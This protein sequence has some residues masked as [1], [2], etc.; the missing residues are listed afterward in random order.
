MACAA[1]RALAQR[2]RVLHPACSASWMW[3]CYSPETEWGTGH[4]HM[5]QRGYAAERAN[6]SQFPHS[7]IDELLYQ[8][9]REWLTDRKV[10]RAFGALVAGEVLA[11]LLEHG[12]A[13]RQVAQMVLER[14]EASD[15]F[16]PTLN[17][18]IPYE[19]HCSASG[20]TASMERRSSSKVVRSGSPRAA[21]YAS[22]S[23]GA[24]AEV[25]H[26]PSATH[27]ANQAGPSSR[28]PMQPPPSDLEAH[29]LLPQ[30]D[31]SRVAFERGTRRQNSSSSR[32][33]RS[34]SLGSSRL[35]SRS[36]T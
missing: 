16:A 18:G 1:R 32:I 22:I 29:P 2:I 12:S 35:I 17:A 27:P 34:R 21:R 4:A 13:V 3:L 7:R 15:G 33:N 25:C 5:P 31:C 8:A 19:M 6:W 23:C 24:M 28:N 20:M 9:A 30:L 14:S 10:Q 36:R 26:H 11:Q